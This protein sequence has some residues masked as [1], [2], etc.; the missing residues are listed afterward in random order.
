MVRV[1]KWLHTSGIWIKGHFLKEPF[2]EGKQEGAFNQIKGYVPQEWIPTLSMKA[3]PCLG[4]RQ[5]LWLCLPQEALCRS[6]YRVQGW[7]GVVEEVVFSLLRWHCVPKPYVAILLCPENKQTSLATAMNRPA[8][9]VPPPSHRTYCIL[10]NGNRHYT[11]TFYHMTWGSSARPN[12]NKWGYWKA[13]FIGQGDS[14]K[15]MHH[16]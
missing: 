2:T 8:G 4:T 15:K 1:S 14:R 5:P 13:S 9:E 6:A 12:P 3:P 10:H 11:D 7:H 16:L